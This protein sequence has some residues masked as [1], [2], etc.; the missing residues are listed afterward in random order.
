MDKHSTA[1]SQFREAL[2]LKHDSA[3]AYYGLALCYHELGQTTNEIQAYKNTLSLKPDMLPALVNLGNAY[4]TQADYESAIRY[5]GRALE[6]RSDDAWIYYNLGSAYS[7]RGDYP[8]AVEAYEHA[9]EV[10]PE[11]GDAHHGLAYGLYMLKQYDRAWKHIQLAKKL[12]ADVSDEQM[13]AIASKA[14]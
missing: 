1:I 9:I 6:I 7:N 5:Y 4:F 2:R 11:I 14:N 8:L 10:D 12:G 3:E 13:R